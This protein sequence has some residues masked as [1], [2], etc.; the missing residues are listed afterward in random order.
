MEI[1]IEYNVFR[2]C[3]Y[4][5]T[6]ISETCANVHTNLI[7]MCLKIYMNIQKHIVVCKYFVVQ[8]CI[9]LS[10]KSRTY[11]TKIQHSMSNYPITKTC[12]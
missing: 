1:S 7:W 9:S 4:L 5:D 3:T 10:R 12:F 6:E 11:L 2:K 8:Y